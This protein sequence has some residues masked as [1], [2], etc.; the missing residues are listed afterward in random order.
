MKIH[1]ERKALLQKE[2]WSD[3]SCMS[4]EVPVRRQWNTI[5][6]SNHSGEGEG[7]NRE[8]NI[9]MHACMCNMQSK[10]PEAAPF[11]CVS[12]MKI[13]KEV[14]TGFGAISHRRI[15]LR[16]WV[17][18]LK[19]KRIQAKMNYC[20][21]FVKITQPCAVVDPA[22]RSG[23]RWGIRRAYTWSCHSHADHHVGSANMQGGFNLLQLQYLQNVPCEGVPQ[24]PFSGGPC[25]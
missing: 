11:T 3:V 25:L 9:C 20:N 24:A 23:N 7:R 22:G 4:T 21:L 15:R 14:T 19:W 6:I 18:D 16:N 2:K 17:N 13:M 8:R 1:Q 12:Q 10:S 5:P